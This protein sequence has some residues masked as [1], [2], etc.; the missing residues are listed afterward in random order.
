MANR[1]ER[2][3]GARSISSKRTGGL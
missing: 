3:L 2:R 1:R